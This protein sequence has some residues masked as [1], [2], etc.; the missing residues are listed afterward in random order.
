MKGDVQE[1]GHLLFIHCGRKPSESTAKM[2]DRSNH[3][4]QMPA[5]NST[6]MMHAF[7]KS[8]YCSSFASVLPPPQRCH[9]ATQRRPA[10]HAQEV[11]PVR[12]ET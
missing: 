2:I 4:F 8:T 5:T 6:D 3:E 11:A 7:P 12:R 1:R 9:S 10:F